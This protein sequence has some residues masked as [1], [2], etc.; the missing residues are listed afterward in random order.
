MNP[1]DLCVWNKMVQGSQ[2]TI[3]FHVDNGII[4][5]KDPLVATHLLCRLDQVY[6]KTDQITICRGGGSRV[7][8]NDHQFLHKRRNRNYYV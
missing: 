5:H 8:G 3:L 6:G 1:Y 7:F 2:L 4:S